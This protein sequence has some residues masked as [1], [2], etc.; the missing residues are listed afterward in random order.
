[1]VTT[2]SMDFTLKLSPNIENISAIKESQVPFRQLKVTADI[3][4]LGDKGKLETEIFH[5]K[6][7]LVTSLNYSVMELYIPLLVHVGKLS[8]STL[9]K[10]EVALKTRQRVVSTQIFFIITKDIEEPEVKLEKVNVIGLSEV[11]SDILF[12]SNG[13]KGKILEGRKSK[14]WKDYIKCGYKHPEAF[15]DNIRDTRVKR[16]LVL[17]K[18]LEIFDDLGADNETEIINGGW[19]MGPMYVRDTNYEKMINDFDEIE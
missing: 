6:G 14:N 13:A 9:F 8:S 1:M 15:T 4:C 2:N 16:S 3:Y 19:F 10:I 17:G 18:A 7:E 12:A 5:R 11:E